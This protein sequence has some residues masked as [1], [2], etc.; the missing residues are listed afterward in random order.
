MRYMLK[1]D[2]SG[3]EIIDTRHGER[4]V[5]LVYDNEEAIVIL[6]YLNGHLEIGSQRQAEFTARLDR[7]QD[8]EG[9]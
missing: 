1:P 6:A 3:S 9:S 4:P 7:R 2:G 8:A 5:A